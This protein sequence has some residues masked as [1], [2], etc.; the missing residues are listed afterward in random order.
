M[1]GRGRRIHAGTILVIVAALTIGLEATAAAA[2]RGSALAGRPLS[3]ALAPGGKLRHGVEGSFSA[4]GYRMVLGTNG[5]P[6][7]VPRGRAAAAAPSVHAAVAADVNWSD[8]YGNVGAP[9]AVTIN[10]VAVSGQSIYIGGSFSQISYDAGLPANNVAMYNGH[11]WYSLGTGAAN[12]VNGQVFALAVSGSTVYVGGNFNSAGASAANAIASWNGS[13]WAP[14]G[15]GLSAPV[16]GNT[17]EVDALALSGTTLYAGGNFDNAGSATVHSIA[18]WSGSAW[19]ALGTGIQN[20]DYFDTPDHCY[21]QPVPSGEV[22]ALAVSGST[23]Y[24]GGSFDLAG[25]HLMAGL[26]RW[27]GSAWAAVGTGG[28]VIDGSSLGYVNSIAVNGANVYVAGRFDHVG[29]TVDSTGGVATQGTAANSIAQWTGSAWKALGSGA[30][31]CSGCGSATVDSV[32]YWNGRVYM[33]GS[34]YGAG[35]DGQ[36]NTAQWSGSAWTPVG[37]NLDSD[38]SALLTTAGGVLAVGGFGATGDSSAYLERIGLWNGT[39]WTGYGLGLSYGTNAGSTGPAAA[40]GN[41]LIVGGNFYTAGS[42]PAHN[43]A[44]LSNGTWSNLDGGLSGGNAVPY[45]ILVSGSDV[46]VGGNF[47]QAGTTAATNIARWDGHAWHALGSGVSGSVDAL[48]MYNGKLWV[49]GSF[50]SAGTTTASDVAIWDPAHSTWSRAGGD[51]HYDG[52]VNA[53]AGEPSGHFMEIAGDFGQV[54]NGVPYPN[55]GYATVNSI[56]RFDTS[57]SS[58]STDPLAGYYVVGT[59]ANVGVQSNGCCNSTYAGTINALLVDGTASYAGGD[60]DI[61]GTVASRGFASYNIST[62]AWSSPGTV[63]GGSG[64]GATVSSILKV[65]TSYYLAGDFSTA[66]NVTANDVAQYTPASKRWAAL[67]SG[68]GGGQFGATG[69]DLAETA[70]GLYVTG[71]MGTAGGKAS[72]N[73]ALWTATQYPVRASQAV[74]PTT[75]AADAKVTFTGTAKN[76]AATAAAEVVLKAALPANAIYS[77]ATPSQGTC[78]RSAQTVTCSLGTLAAGASATVALVVTPI[79]P[80]IATNTITVSQTGAA[81]SSSS[82]ASAGVTAA[83]GFSYASMRDTGFSPTSITVPM[84]N[85]LQYAFFGPAAHTVVDSAAG[86]TSPSKAAPSYYEC[87]Y[88]A[89]GTYTAKEDNASTHTIKVLVADTLSA[90]RVA[91]GTA[92]TVITDSYPV[93]SGWGIDVQVKKPG[94]TTWTQL[95]SGSTARSLSYTPATAGSYQFQS[96]IRNLTSGVANAYG[97]AVA[98]TAT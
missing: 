20:C 98:L 57:T 24:V 28:S 60:F 29:G 77:S 84:G 31:N 10:A 61:A 23:V 78:S 13:H 25:G 17:P 19:S 63:G 37:P 49:G 18:K 12:G 86:C 91:H 5:V 45:A 64:G 69:S 35:G 41:S 72:E 67:G 87:R 21:D 95:A 48:A 22:G 58:T 68:L 85:I 94:S 88:T 73:L 40:Y 43:L 76:T 71:G 93:P 79:L 32:A 65:G 11:G 30:N 6:H 55:T 39:R 44:Q 36:P 80:G 46:Y 38:P 3:D 92:V 9:D 75:Q 52:T 34:F 82:S 97:P 70:D 81:F 33:A 66:G 42:T 4:R 1:H 26:A 74:S 59:G 50:N 7:F 14:L 96:R 54:D 51:L 2:T 16:S 62:H 53:L 15:T 83:A 47:T 8:A 89:G 90:T 56:V 27:T